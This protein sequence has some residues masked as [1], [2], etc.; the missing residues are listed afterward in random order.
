M[1]FSALITIIKNVLAISIADVEIKQLFNLAQDVITYWR[2][3]LNEVIIE[4][5][6]MIKFNLLQH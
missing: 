3:W 6:M 1:I 2:D 4:I 5:I